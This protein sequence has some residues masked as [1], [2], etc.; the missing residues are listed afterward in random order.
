MHSLYVGLVTPE[1]GEMVV[2]MY[3]Y[4]SLRSCVYCKVV[5]IQKRAHS[6]NCFF[7][8]DFNTLEILNRG[9]PAT[10][11]N[12]FH[13]PNCTQALHINDGDLV[14]TH[15]SLQQDC[16]THST[17]LCLAFPTTIQQEKA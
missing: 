7:H 2:V 6:S 16:L 14:D 9:H 11:Y 15:Q 5:G 3:Y 12:T 1:E 17:G 10:P 8:I 4:V 13:A